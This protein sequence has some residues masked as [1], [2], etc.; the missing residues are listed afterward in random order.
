[1]SAINKILHNSTFNFNEFNTFIYFNKMDVSS[2]IFI[3]LTCYIN[4][5]KLIISQMKTM[6]WKKI[7]EEIMCTK[8]VTIPSPTQ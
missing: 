6:H 5:A 2:I 1:M 7:N 4:I 8:L 3:Q